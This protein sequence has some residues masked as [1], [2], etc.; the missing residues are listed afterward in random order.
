MS[1]EPNEFQDPYGRISDLQYW[2]AQCTTQTE[3][4]SDEERAAETLMAAGRCIVDGLPIQAHFSKDLLSRLLESGGRGLAILSDENC[5]NVETLV[6]D[7]TAMD[8]V[9]EADDLCNSI[10]SRRTDFWSVEELLNQFG[11]EIPPVLQ[12]SLDRQDTALRANLN[13]LA[14]VTTSTE[15]QNICGQIAEPFSKQLPW[16]LGEELHR[17][18]ALQRSMFETTTDTAVV[19]LAQQKWWQEIIPAKVSEL[20][21]GLTAND[22][23]SEQMPDPF[24]KLQ[25]R[26][27]SSPDTFARLNVPKRTDASIEEEELALSIWA[28]N[29]EQ[30]TLRKKDLQ[31]MTARIGSR[32]AEF[33]QTSYAV[34]RLRDLRTSLDGLLWISF[35]SQPWE[36]VIE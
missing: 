6:E 32:T 17:T 1:I 34:F 13:V 4:M 3:P 18:V 12:S 15:F 20:F 19:R 29:P 7:W 10:L 36:L 35:D 5:R 26:S 9:W 8:D 16:W 24:A 2:L 14:S 23:S 28:S 11:M 33:D 22:S 31:G 27:R 30:A 21:A 25:W